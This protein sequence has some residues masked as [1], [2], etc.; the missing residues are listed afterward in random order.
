MASLVLPILVE[1]P[2]LLHTTETNASWVVTSTLLA[3]AVA[4]PVMGRLGDMYGKRRMMLI[5]LLLLV[6]GSLVSA[7]TSALVPMLVGRTLQGIGGALGLPAAAIV[8][9][10][11]GWHTLFSGA[12]IL[13]TVCLLLILAFVPEST[14]RS[15]GTFDYVGSLGLGAGLVCLLVPLSESGTWGW[16]DAKTLG[17]FIAAVVLLLA[18]GRYELRVGQPL[19]DLRTTA[20][21]Q[22]LF[23]N[24][25][26]V[27]I[28]F[29]MYGTSLPLPQLLQLPKATG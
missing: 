17:L 19:V 23:T 27:A 12:A 18:W 20:R 10:H 3:A 29:A 28:G 24:L 1:L 9:R 2:E 16:G 5:S 15:G 7:F 25:A 21:R 4:T 26:A 8:A 14:T 13:G 6:A 11:L 22:V